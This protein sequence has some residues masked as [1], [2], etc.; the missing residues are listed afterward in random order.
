[1][2]NIFISN[3]QQMMGQ[4]IL[5]PISD[6]CWIC[7]SVFVGKVLT[8]SFCA[9]WATRVHSARI[10]KI[11]IKNVTKVDSS[12]P[13][14]PS[15]LERIGTEGMTLFRTVL[16]NL[17]KSTGALHLIQLLPKRVSVKLAFEPDIYVPTFWKCPPQ[18]GWSWPS[19]S[20]PQAN[21]C[22]LTL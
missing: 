10:W 1:M 22:S 3:R 20:L 19:L 21:T 13:G 5:F 7:Q 18:A 6:F 15:S 8:D 12:V 17:A 14:E 9:R 4:A 16:L 11:C 2:I